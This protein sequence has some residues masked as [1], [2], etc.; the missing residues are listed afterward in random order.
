VVCEVRA[1][2]Y[3]WARLFFNRAFLELCNE[4]QKQKIRKL[5]A[6]KSKTY[7]QS[8]RYRRK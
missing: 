8:H 1:G 4:R 5:D 7:K 6:K 2:A 3:A